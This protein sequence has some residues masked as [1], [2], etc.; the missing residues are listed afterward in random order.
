[1]GNIMGDIF[2]HKNT[3][4]R[5]YGDSD[6]S[7]LFCFGVGRSLAAGYHFMDTV[8]VNFLDGTFRIFHDNKSLYWARHCFF[9]LLWV[10]Q[11]QAFLYDAN[12]SDLPLAF[13]TMISCIH[14]ALA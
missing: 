7:Y 14:F 9:N 5:C 10:G 2:R 8:I 4:I 1:M 6:N 11:G 13:W 12:P 3:T